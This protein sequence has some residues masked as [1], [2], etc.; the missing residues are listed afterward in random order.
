M[1]YLLLNR[2]KVQ[3]ANAIA[4]FT[5]GFP[6]ITH[7]L[8]FTH[9][10]E[11]KLAS[12]DSL[13]D[14]TLQGCGVISHQQETH[15]FWQ[16]DK[17]FSQHRY[18]P[19]LQDSN[20][21]SASPPIIE[22]GKMNM[23]I[24]LVIGIKGNV[25]HRKESFI[26]FIESCALTQKLAGGLIL[27]IGE[28]SLLTEPKDI[29]R[30]LMPGFVLIERPNY[31]SEHYENLQDN[32]PEADFLQAWLDFSALKQAARPNHDL[33][34]KYIEQTK[35][36]ALQDAWQSHLKVKPY[37]PT[38]I[39]Q[40][41]V[42]HFEKIAED[43]KLKKLLAQWKDYLQPSEKSPAQWEVLPKP[44]PGFLVPLMTGYKAISK[45]YE[46]HEVANTRDHETPVC[47]VEAV[48]SIGEW[49]SPHKIESL[50]SILWHYNYE[51]PWYLCKQEL[52]FIEPSDSNDEEDDNDIFL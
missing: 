12:Q 30:K 52:P 1:T 29:K 18:Q 4:G 43:K 23:T 7:F 42:Q 47:F 37:S 48:H 8:G 13:V 41:L 35:D 46:N 5:W 26:H 24:S 39:P 45:V 20:N 15:T 44:A 3:N 31:L 50:E 51:N 10:I 28:I 19:Y 9:A 40:A 21:K 17:S 38:T 36:E 6:A 33:I 25:G 14:I 16:Y 2:I 22:E 49:R 11:R 27:E 34:S 32:N